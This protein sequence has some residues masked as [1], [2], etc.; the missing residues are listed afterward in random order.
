[1]KSEYLA[2]SYDAGRDVPLHAKA[3]SRVRDMN[4]M[5]SAVYP[6]ANALA[7]FGPLR[8]VAN[9]MLGLAPQRSLPGFGP[10]LYRWNRRRR[11]HVREDAPTVI[12]QPDCFTVYSEPHIGRAAI[13]VL[14]ALGYRVVLPELGCCGR[15]GISHGL[16]SH[17]RIECRDTADDLIEAVRRADAVAVVGLEP[18]CISSIVDDWL[19]LTI[20]VDQPALRELAAKTMGVEDFIATRW[21]EHPNRVDVV[22][23][24]GADSPVV[25]HGHC[26]QKALWGMDGTV[27]VLQRIVG[28]HLRVLDTGCCGMAGSFGYTADHYDVSMAVA[29]SSLLPQLREHDDAT[30]LSP[31]TSCRHQIHDAVRRQALHPIELVAQ[32]MRIGM[33]K[34]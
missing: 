26:H 28:D 14:E 10:S 4:R 7:R 22:A 31:G 12:L 25:L 29:A 15:P 30:I 11:S 9:R 24:D 16:L 32:Q 33:R 19:D 6:V 2:Q 27:D 3:F 8:A 20:D 17:A 21:N 23:S 34:G 13:A 5:G 1:M 18:S